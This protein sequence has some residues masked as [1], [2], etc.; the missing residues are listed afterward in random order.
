LISLSHKMQLQPYVTKFGFENLAVWIFDALN[1][2][3]ECTQ[4]NSQ[5][6]VTSAHPQKSFSINGM[7]MLMCKFRLYLLWIY[8]H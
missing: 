7:L 4:L 1:Y 8:R 3:I 5:C 6:N 2:F